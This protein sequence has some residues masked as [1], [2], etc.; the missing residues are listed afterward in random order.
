MKITL[1]YVKTDDGAK[2]CYDKKDI[3]S[4]LEDSVEDEDEGLE[5][6]YSVDVNVDM[7]NGEIIIPPFDVE[8][9]NPIRVGEE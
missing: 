8:L 3:P 5:P 9:W 7:T 1:Y 6:V 2:F 4:I